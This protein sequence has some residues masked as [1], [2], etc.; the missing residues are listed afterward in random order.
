M[1]GV[2]A[3]WYLTLVPTKSFFSPW[4]VSP[5][6]VYMLAATVLWVVGLATV[7]LMFVVSVVT[8]SI[9]FLV[10]KWAGATPDGMATRY[11]GRTATADVALPQSS[12]V[13]MCPPHARTG[14]AWFAVKVI[15]IAVELSPK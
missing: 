9:F 11:V 12:R 8:F 5:L 1:T 2:F 15:E 14:L 13:E 3:G 10:P 7:G 4:D 6:I